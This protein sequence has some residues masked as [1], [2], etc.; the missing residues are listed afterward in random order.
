MR[1]VII[2]GHLTPAISV[3]DAL[4]KEAE[5]LYIGRKYAMEGDKAVSLEF[6]TITDRGIRFEVIKTG[7][8]QRQF[9]RHT[10]PS[11]SRVPYGIAQSLLILRRFK[12]DVVVGFGGYVSFP[13]IAAAKLLKIPVVI[14]EQT[15]EVGFANKAVSKMA[16]KICISFFSSAKYFSKEKVVLTGNPIRSSIL[17]PSKRF[18]LS[19]KNPVIYVTGGS[20]GSHF[21]NLMVS[22]VLT[23]LLEKYTVIHQTGASEEFKDYD[24]LTIL[25]DGLNKNKENYLLSKFYS[26]DIVGSIL[27]QADL[28]VS[29]AGVNTISEL[30][31]LRKPSYL[32]P[33]P[34]SQKDEQHKNAEF[35]RNLGLGEIGDQRSLTPE[36]FLTE[37]NE[38]MD[39]LGKYK[40]KS[41]KEHFPKNAADRIVEVIYAASKNHN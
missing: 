23:R 4:P 39:N 10:L 3:I 12:P 38:M 41:S 18:R 28:V 21:I 9:S 5:V 7:R 11:M 34:V 8:I 16:D 26:E 36:R 30:I 27:K 25:K 22:G 2:G 33:L 17:N 24:K 20:Q 1:I 14:H 37:I 19:T 40:L 13:V 31:V 29:R 35:L 15:L 6:Q 32:I